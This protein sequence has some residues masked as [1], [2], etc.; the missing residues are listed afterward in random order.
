MLYKQTGML[1]MDL[2]VQLYLYNF[3][4]EK[5]V[6]EQREFLCYGNLPWLHAYAK[7]LEHRS[8]NTQ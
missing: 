3:A 2:C 7:C 1:Y 5:F 4:T 8:K 6:V